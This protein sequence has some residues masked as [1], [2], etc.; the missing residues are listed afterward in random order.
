MAAAVLAVSFSLRWRRAACA[1]AAGALLFGFAYY[2]FFAEAKIDWNVFP[3]AGAPAEARAVSDVSRDVSTQRFTAE[4]LPPFRGRFS[5][6]MGD[7]PVV[8]YGDRLR[9]AFR[10]PPQISAARIHLPPAAAFPSV[11]VSGSGGSWLK[12]AAFA[13]KGRLIAS[14]AGFFPKDEA[15]LASGMTTGD[16]SGFSDGFI[17]AMRASGTAHIVAVS[18]YNVTILAAAVAATLGWFF[19]RRAVLALSLCAIGFFVV[20]VGGGASVV[21]AAVMGVLMLLSQ[22]IG[23]LYDVK[24]AAAIAAAAMIAWNPFIISRDVGFLLSFASLI[25][26]VYLSP[27]A[28]RWLGA[29]R[30]GEKSFLGLRETA[31]ATLGA[32]VM[33]LPI[34]LTWFGSLSPFSA[35]ANVL[36]LG[37]VPL[38]MLLGVVVGLG[39]AL[40]KPLVFAAAFGLHALLAYEVR[41]IEFF[42]G[43][44]SGRF[45]V[46]PAEWAPWF[47]AAYYGL[48]GL[49]FVFH[50]RRKYRA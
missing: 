42:G 36:I 1:V 17:A 41:V 12:K 2:F 13:L 32:Q 18:G 37:F 31:A 24:N 5:V 34:A 22:G 46:L 10:E 48:V 23:R 19:A 38:T 47:A 27:L 43:L 50:A 30:S 28:E 20:S 29:G 45:G 9:L 21:R 40:F 26:V 14:F 11:E 6:M 25:G 16:Q 39:A 35:A 44:P 8:H 7:A 49:I 15:A 33:V 4:F 3:P